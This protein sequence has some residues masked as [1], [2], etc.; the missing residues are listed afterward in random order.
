MRQHMTTIHPGTEKER[1]REIWWYS[2]RT[3]EHK[4]QVG[5]DFFPSSLCEAFVSVRWS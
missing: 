4:D 3:E 2:T 5:T 1:N